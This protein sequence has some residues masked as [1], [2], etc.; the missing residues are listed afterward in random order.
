[1]VYKDN[2]NLLTGCDDG[3]VYKLKMVLPLKPQD[4]KAHSFGVNKLI[5]GFKYGIIKRW[6]ISYNWIKW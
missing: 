6:K 1:M 2:T 5:E 3:H 4:F